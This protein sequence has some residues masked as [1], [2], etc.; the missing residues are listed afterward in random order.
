[1]LVPGFAVYMAE[2]CVYL[3]KTL[4]LHV[5]TVDTNLQTVGTCTTMG[6]KVP[7][8]PSAFAG[9]YSIHYTT[10]SHD[11]ASF[12]L[13]WCCLIRLAELGRYLLQIPYGGKICDNIRAGQHTACHTCNPD[14]VTF[15][16][17]TMGGRWLKARVA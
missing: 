1:M 11:L 16:D 5:L 7:K 3:A 10:T 14:R 15:S 13:K 8:R 4:R 12:L 6:Q 2:L 17:Q 9:S